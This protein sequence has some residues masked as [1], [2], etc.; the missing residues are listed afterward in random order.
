M[1]LESSVDFSS[2]LEKIPKNFTGADFYGLTS[3]TV[4]KA[5]R[6]KIKEIESIYQQRKKENGENYS[7]NTFS[8]EIITSMKELREVTVGMQDFEEALYKI[9]PSV[10]E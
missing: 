1:K 8:E 7:F 4:L 9:T 5:A 6:R 2:L 3:Q 10:S